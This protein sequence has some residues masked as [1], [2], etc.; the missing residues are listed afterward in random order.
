MKIFLFI[1]IF[2][3]SCLFTFSAGAQ[4]N[5][6]RFSLSGKISDTSGAPLAG[7]SIYIPDLKKG[8]V[9]DAEGNFQI[10]NIPSGD[11]LVEIKYIGYKTIA[12]S[13]NFD[14]DKTENFAMQIAVVEESAIVI[15]GSSRASSIIRNPCLL[16]TS[17]AADE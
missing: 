10:K 16:Y 14:Q 7:A 17:D 13:I 8:I 11:Y 5:A 15:T 3:A 1:I 4:K 6:T 9:A 12:Q 2:S